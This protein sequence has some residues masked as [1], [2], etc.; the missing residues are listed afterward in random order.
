MRQFGTHSGRIG[1]ASAAANA[2]VAIERW[3]QHGSWRSA[4]AQRG[5]MQLPEENILSVSR[6][7]M[8]DPS[9]HD[10]REHGQGDDDNSNDANNGES[11]PEVEGAPEGAFR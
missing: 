2:G 10:A 5:Y 1:G 7:I 3:G 11:N 9:T 4:S 6:A 8:A